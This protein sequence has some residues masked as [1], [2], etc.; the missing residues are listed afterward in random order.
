MIRCPVI[1]ARIDH[2]GGIAPDTP[3]RESTI[4][5]LSDPENAIID[6]DPVG[7]IVRG[8][9]TVVNIIG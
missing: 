9:G 8:P 2:G 1:V 4:A 6:G 3:H 5:V 7:N